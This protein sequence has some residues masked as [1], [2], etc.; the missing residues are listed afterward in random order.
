MPCNGRTGGHDG[1]HN[2]AGWRTGELYTLVNFKKRILKRLF[3]PFSFLSLFSALPPV[4]IFRPLPSLLISTEGPW[5]VSDGPLELASPHSSFHKIEKKSIDQIKD[6]EVP[7][8]NGGP[9]PRLALAPASPVPLP[10]RRPGRLPGF[11][12][13]SNP[14]PQ[15]AIWLPVSWTKHLS[16]L[17]DVQLPAL[18]CFM[19]PRGALISLSAYINERITATS[20]TG[21]QKRLSPGAFPPQ[22]SLIGCNAE[23]LGP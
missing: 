1:S 22:I 11:P 10:S 18:T 21:H 7:E 12:P 23:P 6:W 2:G 5:G 16:A 4:G 14:G 20:R 17:M 15:V 8:E 13:H 9:E 3:L 19:P